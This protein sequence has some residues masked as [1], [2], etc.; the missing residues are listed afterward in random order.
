MRNDEYRD[1]PLTLAATLTLW[2]TGVMSGIFVGVFASLPA[3]AYAALVAFAMGF[4]P[5]VVLVDRRVR[6]WLSLKPGYAARQAGVA[7]AASLAA[8]G[9]GGFASANEATSWAPILLFGIPLAIAL[10]LALM[11]ERWGNKADDAAQSLSSVNIPRF[12]QDSGHLISP[13]RG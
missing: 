2:A 9:F 1:V 11:I 3:E 7:I 5:F 10:L 8:V 4:A 6:K 13:P 12:G